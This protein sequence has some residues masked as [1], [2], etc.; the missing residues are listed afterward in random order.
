MGENRRLLAHV[1]ELVDFATRARVGTRLV[2]FISFDVLVSGVP[3]ER[4]L[5]SF[6]VGGLPFGAPFCCVAHA[7]DT[8]VVR[9]IVAMGPVLQRV[10]LFRRS[11][12]FLFF[13]GDRVRYLL[14]GQKAA[15]DVATF[16]VEVANCTRFVVDFSFSGAVSGVKDVGTRRAVVGRPILSA[17]LVLVTRYHVPRRDVCFHA[18]DAD[19]RACL[20]VVFLASGQLARRGRWRC[21]YCGWFVRGFRSLFASTGMRLGVGWFLAGAVF[22]Y[23]S[24]LFFTLLYDQGDGIIGLVVSVKGSMT[25]LTVFSGNRLIRM[26]HNSG[27]S[28][29]YL[30]VLYS[31]CPLGQNVVTSIV[32]LDGAVQRRLRELPFG[33]VRLD[34]RAPI[35]IAGLC[36]APRALN[37]SHL[38]TI[39][40][41]G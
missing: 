15:R 33:V 8:V 34:R 38:T 20:C 31:Q 1:G 17:Y 35:P 28:L 36:G 41:T 12:R 24:C 39:I 3:G 14:V 27:R 25:G 11:S 30:P 23:C 40:T 18:K 22:C 10:V 6:E 7:N 32:A 26:F 9:G 37:V 4:P 16:G 2:P 21:R 19:R 5:L 29:S 13:Q